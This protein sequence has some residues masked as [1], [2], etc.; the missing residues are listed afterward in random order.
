MNSLA[1]IIHCNVKLI[2]SLSS[3]CLPKRSVQMWGPKCV[4]FSVRTCTLNVVKQSDIVLFQLGLFNRLDVRLFVCFYNLIIR[5]G[6]HGSTTP[7]GSL[8]LSDSLTHMYTRSRTH[9]HTHTHK[10]ECVVHVILMIGDHVSIVLNLY[11]KMT[12]GFCL[13]CFEVEQRAYGIVVR[14]FRGLVKTFCTT[15]LLVRWLKRLFK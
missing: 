7:L 10:H 12:P 13:C 4:E 3:R 1:I 5:N 6:K 15:E 14:N 11:K 9:K 8:F 2:A